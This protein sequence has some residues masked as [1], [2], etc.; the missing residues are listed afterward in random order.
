MNSQDTLVHLIWNRYTYLSNVS[1]IVCIFVCYN[2]KNIGKC[3][4]RNNSHEMHQI[5]VH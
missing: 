4:T 3:V 2:W 5:C 1:L